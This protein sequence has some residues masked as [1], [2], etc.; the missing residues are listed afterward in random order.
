MKMLDADVA[1]RVRRSVQASL[2]DYSPMQMC[3]RV[4][5]ARGTYIRVVGIDARVG[6]L[7][8]IL[9][10][11]SESQIAEVTGLANDGLVLMPRNHLEGL[12]LG[13]RV[14][15]LH[16]ARRVPIGDA[17][18]GRVLDGFGVP[19]DGRGPV[20]TDVTAPVNA[21]SPDPLSR[22][23]V[24]APFV[25]GVRAVDALLTV[26]H[27]QRIGIFSPAGTGK[28]TL[29]SMILRGADVDM[30]VV[31]LVGERGREVEEFVHRT[32]GEGRMK[33]SVVVAATSD[34]S[35]SERVNAAF[36][37]TTIA[38]GFR[39]AGKRVLFVMDSVTRFAR[40]LR[41]I[42]LASGE[43]PTRRG[44]PPSVF[45]AL[46]KLMERAGNN[47]HGS[48]TAVYTV[49]VEGEE[50]EDPIAEEVRSIL[51]GH[52]VLSRS[53]SQLP[54]YP[55][56]DLLTSLSRLMPAVVSADHMKAAWRVRSLMARFQEIE[57]LVRVGE[58]RAGSDR[59]SDDAIARAPEVRAFMMQP[60]GELVAFDD[61]LRAL[62]RLAR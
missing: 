7:C 60:P 11:E 17:L 30:C 15:P 53:I 2:G 34:A 50:A 59:M 24:V 37:A 9:L 29:A 27:G 10:S 32:L 41:E 61:S 3:G 43:P 45:A 47:R 49:L 23:P 14:K 18:L 57:L 54:Q 40:A 56:I 51:D 28:S 1:Q 26:G 62:V 58:Y 55:A 25:S 5:E 8:E 13:S 6:E 52:I 42:G 38:E 4:V 44:F 39:D 48:I 35:A 33:R 12:S 16:R 19:I 36:A 46:P 21:A 22:Q 31:A 20:Q